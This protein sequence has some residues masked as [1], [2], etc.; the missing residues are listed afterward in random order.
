MLQA[1]YKYFK[2]T[3]CALS[4]IAVPLPDVPLADRSL[5]IVQLVSD[6]PVYLGGA[7]VQTMGTFQGL[8]LPA[9]YSSAVLDS[10][11]YAQLYGIASTP[12][13]VIVLE[14]A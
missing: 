6:G 3:K 10:K 1:V 8:M 9:K 4:N 12:Q 13:D 14:G 5:L 11:I 2:S 7:N